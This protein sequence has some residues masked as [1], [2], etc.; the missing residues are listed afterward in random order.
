MQKQ[1]SSYYDT[2]SFIITLAA[3]VVIGKYLHGYVEAATQ[4]LMTF[5]QSKTPE[6]ILCLLAAIGL[7]S[8]VGGFFLTRFGRWVNKTWGDTATSIL[9]DIILVALVAVAAFGAI[10]AVLII[11]WGGALFAGMLIA[12]MLS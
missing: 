6:M 2:V 8:A 4:P 9:A 12:A 1:R 10:P 5:L 11:V 3:I 7:A